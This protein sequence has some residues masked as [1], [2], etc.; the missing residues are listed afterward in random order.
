MRKFGSLGFKTLSASTGMAKIDRSKY[1][2]RDGKDMTDF[3]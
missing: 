3:I 1:Q 2:D